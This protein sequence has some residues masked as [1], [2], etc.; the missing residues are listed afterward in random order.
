M[1][2][3]E[4][5][6]TWISICLTTVFSQQG[7][8]S[9]FKFP[10]RFS[11]LSWAKTSLYSLYWLYWLYN[12]L[13]FLSNTVTNIIWILHADA[14]LRSSASD[15]HK[16]KRVYEEW[17]RTG[18]KVD[19]NGFP[20]LDRSSS[21]AVLKFLLPKID[22]KGELRLKD[23][24]TIKKCKGGLGGIGRGMTWDEHMEAAV[25]ELRAK[26][27]AP[28]FALGGANVFFSWRGFSPSFI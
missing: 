3:C 2:E 24:G 7:G 19:A 22:I 14:S 1:R 5:I 28:L 16:A 4:N 6:P 12:D 17:T 18:R 23:F 20:D 11:E 15:S 26:L 25:A 27:G 13:S 21:Y 10:K 8:I 9:V